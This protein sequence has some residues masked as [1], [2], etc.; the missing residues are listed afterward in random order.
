MKKFVAAAALSALV[1]QP[2]LAG[3]MAEPV[4]EPE[5]IAEESVGTGGGWVVPLILIALVAAVASASGSSDTPMTPEVP[6]PSL[7]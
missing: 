1:A 4:M 6:M 3:G 5:V 2:A 7:Q